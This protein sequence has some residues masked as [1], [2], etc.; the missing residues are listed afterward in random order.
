MF[1][2]IQTVNGEGFGS[3]YMEE[4]RVELERRLAQMGDGAQL[5]SEDE[6]QMAP[7]YL[8]DEYDFWILPDLHL[9][10]RVNVKALVQSLEWFG[11]KNV[12][13]LYTTEERFAEVVKGWPVQQNPEDGDGWVAL[14]LS[15]ASQ[16][17][18]CPWDLLD[19]WNWAELLAQQPQFAA[20]CDWTKLDDRDW[21]YLLVATDAFDEHCNFPE[22]DGITW[23]YLL[24]HRPGLS[25]RFDRKWLKE[26]SDRDASR[27]VRLLEAGEGARG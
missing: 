8:E 25:S 23:T 17:G 11:F 24:K 13:E 21:S 12:A 22:L 2:M 26:M 20:H 6:K 16:G 18:R 5:S 4:L 27:I 19:G 14:L 10:Y 15:D 1:Q 9:K 3:M 7:N